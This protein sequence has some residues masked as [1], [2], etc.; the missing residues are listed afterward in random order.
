VP[1]SDRI[2]EP[3]RETAPPPAR[4]AGALVPGAGVAELFILALIGD[5]FD[6]LRG[7]RVFS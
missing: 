7:V 1:H 3:P 2:V 6:Q 5:L 4:G